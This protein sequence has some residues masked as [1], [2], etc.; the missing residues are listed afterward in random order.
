MSRE[1]EKAE[2]IEHK[3]PLELFGDFYALQNNQKMSEEQEQYMTD[4]I[5][6]MTEGER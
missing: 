3:T 5:G 6:K 1:I 2:E 4:L